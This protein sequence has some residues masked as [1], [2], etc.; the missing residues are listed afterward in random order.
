MPGPALALTDTGSWCMLVHLRQRG[1]FFFSHSNDM[2][3][4]GLGH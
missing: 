1:Q 4:G 2:P 3:R